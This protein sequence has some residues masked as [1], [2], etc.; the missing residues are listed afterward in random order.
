M[1]TLSKSILP[2]LVITLC[3]F[4]SAYS[5]LPFNT[6]PQTG[7]PNKSIISIA[8]GDITKQK[9]ID[10]IV[11][12]ANFKYLTHPGG[13]AAAV[14]KAAGPSW[15]AEWKQ[16]TT[17]P[18]FGDKKDQKRAILTS[19]HNLTGNNIKY[20]L[21]AVGPQGTERD[22]QS[23]LKKTYTDALMV[24]HENNLT[25]IAFPAISTGIFAQD[26]SGKTVITPEIAAN[27]AVEATQEFLKAHPKTPLQKISFV[28]W[29][30]AAFAAYTAALS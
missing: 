30:A 23:K 25:S 29:D 8:Q 14:K 22:W 1:N 5:I 15:D 20:I 2:S 16:A 12:A 28:V 21:N 4:S 24:A 13:I 9:D 11:N 26:A 17:N 19:A 7:E 27:T 6:C 10:A 3:Y 18:K